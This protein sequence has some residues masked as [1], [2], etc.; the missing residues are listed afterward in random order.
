M[1][2]AFS[3]SA[4]IASLLCSILLVIGTSSCSSTS[5]AAISDDSGVRARV[6]VLI[7]EINDN[8]DNLHD[9][10]TPAVH[11]LA[12]IGLASLRNGVL[13]LLLNEDMDTRYRAQAVLDDVTAFEYGFVM[14]RGWKSKEDQVA[15]QNL[16]TEM[17]PYDYRASK[18][19]RKAS[20]NRWADW[21]AR[22]SKEQK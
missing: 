2:I 21:V 9:E 10:H 7:S 5:N 20:Y 15:W 6:R 18:A 17:G 1:K 4:L 11:E 14:G 16:R 8:P 13:E 12:V 22:R 3:R 19:N